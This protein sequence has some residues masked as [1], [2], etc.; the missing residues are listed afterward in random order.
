MDSPDHRKSRNR[1]ISSPKAGNSSTPITFFLKKESEISRDQADTLIDTYGSPDR[2]RERSL[3]SNKSMSDSSFGVQSLSDT[4]EEAFPAQ[5]RDVSPSTASTFSQDGT[6]EDSA[7]GALA[8][9]Y[10]QGRKRKAGNRIH[11][12]IL[13]TAQR[14][15][16]G[17]QSSARSSL[18]S[19]PAY[20]PPSA[21]SRE[22]HRR[23]G[24]NISL[25]RSPSPL[26]LGSLPGSELTGTPRSASLRSLRLSDEEGSI[27]DDAGSQA[28][29]GSSSEEEGEE[30]VT[31]G[32]DVI[33]GA[34]EPTPLGPQL[35]MPSISMPS[36][37]PF[38]E[39]G[40]RMGKLKVLVAGKAGSG[41]TSLIKSIVQTCED[42]VHVDPSSPVKLQRDPVG[43]LKRDRRSTNGT[44]KQELLSDHAFAEINA[45]TKPY[46]TWWSDV[47]ESRTLRRRKSLGD[48]V[49]ER[50]LTFIDTP[51]W[52]QDNLG[53]A[54][55]QTDVAN[56]IETLM[57]QNAAVGSMTESQ[58]LSLLTSGGGSQVDAVLYLLSGIPQQS[59]AALLRQISRWTNVIPI[60]SRSDQYCDEELRYTTDEIHSAFSYMDIKVFDFGTKD[61]TAHEE[62]S[63]NSVYA[64]SSSPGDN[65]DEMDASLL[66]SSDYIGPLLSSEL[67][68]L[69]QNLFDPEH[70][71]WL[72]HTAVKKYLVWR[73]EQLSNTFD[74]QAQADFQPIL[75]IVKRQHNRVP[76]SDSPSTISSN[77]GALV[78]YSD[79][80]I[81]QSPVPAPP[82]RPDSGSDFYRTARLE[83]W[84]QD[85]QINLFGTQRP[86][87]DLPVSEPSESKAL[88]HRRQPAPPSS[89][90]I[91]FNADDPLNLFSLSNT[92]RTNLPLALRIVGIGS[93]LGALAIY[94]MRNWSSI[95]SFFSGAES[96]SSSSAQQPIVADHPSWIGGRLREGF[97]DWRRG[98]VASGFGPGARECVV[99][100]GFLGRGGDF[101]GRDFF[102]GDGGVASY[103]GFG[104]LGDVLSE[105]GT[106]GSWLRN[107]GWGDWGL[108]EGWGL[109]W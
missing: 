63:P 23:L 51:G 106:G 11:P 60:L 73:R 66:M 83:K 55:G 84:A 70:M 80:S 30:D 92:L 42:I 91:S 109:A 99:G 94:A 56:L 74:L 48:V 95:V 19:R 9:S 12:T 65:D 81:P 105:Y 86:K 46:P 13:A 15:I 5:P 59:E 29:Q 38:T 82:Q 7:E 78:P 1:Q 107:F 24:S 75:G 17:D 68:R 104:G 87:H 54:T 97:E 76:S 89:R 37:R 101:G 10:L 50:N 57:R 58:L 27:V 39:R 52:T 20:T 6:Q 49:L 2:R 67:P 28:I 88:T 41:K 98:F 35:V 33:I 71:L 79:V 108:G 77:S 36:R 96:S 8:S 31:H 64:V 3:D 72:R 85:L 26:H 69:I 61:S 34:D 53:N 16:S 22:S 32:E 40:R 14:I 103:G 18:G 21:T 90:P 93:A 4:L 43:Q 25:D 44:V 47:D 62:G 100:E 102:S 45:S